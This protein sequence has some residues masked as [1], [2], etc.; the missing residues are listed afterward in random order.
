VY[1]NTSLR[2]K[3]LAD[4]L[5]P[6]ITCT[7]SNVVQTILQA[8]AQVP[9][10]HVWY[11]PDT[12]MGRNVAQLFQMLSQLPD[13]EVQRLHPAHTAATVREC[14]PRLRH[15]DQGMCAV[16]HMFGGQVCQAVR[17]AYGDAY[18]TAHF[19]VPGEMFTLAMEARARGMGVVGSTQNILDFIAEK[20][21]EAQE[22]K[23]PETLRFVLGTETGMV[24]S[25]V[26]KVQAMLRAADTRDVQV[27]IVFPVSVDAVAPGE[28]MP[29][30]P[31]GLPG[32][33]QVVPGP[34]GGEGCSP[35][36]GC[37]SC[38]FMKMNDLQGLLSVCRKVGTP[39]EALLEGH[40]PRAY[41]ETV[42]G[43]SIAQAGCRSILHMRHF[44]QTKR[45]SEDLERDI[46]TRAV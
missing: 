4:D 29:A 18:L 3:A 26:R 17:D 38:P 25:I 6:T 23:V 35:E 37:A 45:L 2:T 10:C 36:G 20:V 1:I 31:G 28:S 43:K 41:S 30:A 11:G 33:L 42:G 5:V 21:G 34:A 22:R 7:S 24:T 27:D 13:E 8:F 32:G 16:H 39:G 9:D 14:L 15:Y 46:L 19:E 44:Q 40:R 12:Y